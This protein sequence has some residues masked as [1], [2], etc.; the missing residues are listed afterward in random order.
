M[1]TGRVWESGV[2]WGINGPDVHTAISTVDIYTPT[3]VITDLRGP[4]R[5]TAWGSQ[6]E[7]ETWMSCHEER[8]LLAS[9]VY[10][11]VLWYFYKLYINYRRLWIHLLRNQLYIH[12]YFDFS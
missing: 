12:E 5:G 4:D 6:G 1:G 9:V 3:M 2:P 10:T 8:M 11:S 7:G